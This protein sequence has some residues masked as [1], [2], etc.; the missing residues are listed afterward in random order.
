MKVEF[1]SPPRTE[2]HG[3]AVLV[4][5]TADGRPVRFR[6]ARDAIRSVAPSAADG[7]DLTARLTSHAGRFAAVAARKLEAAGGAAILELTV[8]EADV[9]AA[10]ECEE[11][12]IEEPAI[13]GPAAEAAPGAGM[14]W[15]DDGGWAGVR[16]DE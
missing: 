2:F 11:A 10:D 15:S 4:D 14:R 13:T 9:L 1:R 6:F 7:R 5:G 8:T 3:E 16:D 12:K